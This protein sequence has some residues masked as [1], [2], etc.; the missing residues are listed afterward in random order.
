M[1]SSSSLSDRLSEWQIHDNNEQWK[2]YYGRGFEWGK[3]GQRAL[4][5][6]SLLTGDNLS[7]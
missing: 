7:L 3:C 5:I 6:L 1:L 2:S 4:R